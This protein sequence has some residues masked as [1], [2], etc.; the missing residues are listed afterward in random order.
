MFY[1][2]AMVFGLAYGGMVPLT[3]IVPAELFGLKAFGVIY[4]GLMLVSTIGESLGA[5]VA[6][7]IFD[8][9]GQYWPAFLICIV[10]GSLA[11]TLGIMVMTYSRKRLNSR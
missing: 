6:G 2:F 8:K 7:F 5:P 11:I 9:T 10:L 3:A 4:A 1:L